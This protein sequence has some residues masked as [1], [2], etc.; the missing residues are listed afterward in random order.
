MKTPGKDLESGYQQGLVL[1]N[2]IINN[3]AW[4]DVAVTVKDHK[5]GQPLQILHSNHGLVKAGD[6]L[7]LMGPSGSG[8]TTLLNVLAHRTSAMKGTTSGKVMINGQVINQAALRRVSSYVEQED[9]MIGILTVYETISFAARLSLTHTLSKQDRIARV[10]NLVEGFGL[11]R[12]KGTI[13]GTPL[14]KGI[15]GGQKRRLSVASQL[16]T[17]PRILFLDEPTSGLD[18]AASYEVMKYIRLVA[19]QHRLIVLA[20]I[21][22]PSTTTFQLFDQLML[23]SEGRTC[24][25]GPTNDVQKYFE[26]IKMPMPMHT[27]PAEFL[28]ELVN[29]DF[30]TAPQRTPD[31][32]QYIQ[33]CWDSSE[34][35]KASIA[36]CDNPATRKDTSPLDGLSSPQPNV[37]SVSWILLHRNFIKSYRDFIAYGTRVVMYLGLAILMGTS[38][39]FPYYYSSHSSSNH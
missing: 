28:L 35:R 34:E 5:T 22:Q 23:L 26:Q 2:D 25:S 31:Q 20:S 9:A 16:V 37:L 12:Q 29:K 15:S 7:A 13:V 17:S 1:P 8:K 3:F 14:R 11:E 6:V 10:D 24:Y 38:V 39:P 27:N 33:N 18:S 36:S 32:L 21:H 30:V 19:K 4:S